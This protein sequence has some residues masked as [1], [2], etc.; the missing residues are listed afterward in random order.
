MNVSYNFFGNKEQEEI[1]RNLFSE[2][3]LSIPHWVQKLQISS[4]DSGENSGVTAECF[5]C[6]RYLRAEIK[7]YNSF[8]SQTKEEQLV[9]V[10]HEILHLHRDPVDDLVIGGMLSYIEKTNI[11]VSEVYRHIFTNEMENFI[12]HFANF[13]AFRSFNEKTSESRKKR[14]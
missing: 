5:P 9:T 6:K 2:A 7:I 3:L 14:K 10:Y 4:Y 11:E 13:L 12:E 8:F 1:A